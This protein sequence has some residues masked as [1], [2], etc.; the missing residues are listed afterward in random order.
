MLCSQLWQKRKRLQKLADNAVNW[1]LSQSCYCSPIVYCKDCI[2]GNIEEVSYNV[3]NELATALDLD[4]VSFVR[5]RNNRTRV[6]AIS[7][8]TIPEARSSQVRIWNHSLDSRALQ[9]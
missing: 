7:G 8:I 1:L 2:E 6:V 3:V 9:M 5:F 4:R